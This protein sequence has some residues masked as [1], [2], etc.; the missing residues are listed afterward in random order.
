[1]QIY[2]FKKFNE[3]KNVEEAEE[4]LSLGTITFPIEKHF[5]YKNSICILKYRNEGIRFNELDKLKNTN[6]IRGWKFVNYAM[7]D[8]IN[9]QHDIDVIFRNI[10]NP[11][12]ELTSKNDRS[13]YQ[14]LK[15]VLVS[16]SLYN[17]N[18]KIIDMISNIPWKIHRIG[19]G[20]HAVI[21][22][23]DSEGEDDIAFNTSLVKGITL[24]DKGQCEVMYPGTED[25]LFYDSEAEMIIDLIKNY[26]ISKKFTFSKFIKL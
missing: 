20:S 21:Q 22:N 18:K 7:S 5:F 14:F 12:T 9:P 11:P 25:P 13:E 4:F 26:V 15:I 16:E 24:Y 3:S 23:K 1:M 6:R 17:Q 19:F 10:N 8:S 2:R